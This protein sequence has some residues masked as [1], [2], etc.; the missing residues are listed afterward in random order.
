ERVFLVG[1]RD[2]RRFRFPEPT[3]GTLDQISADLFGPTREPY[4]NAWDVLGDL[5]E[6][7]LSEPGL[8]VG[9]KWGDLLPTIPE[10]EN[11]LWHTNRGGG[12]SLFGWR[13]RYWS[14][15]LKLSKSLPSWTVQ[16]QPGS[17]IGPFHWKNRRLTFQE[18]CRIQT[19]PDGLKIDCGRSEMQ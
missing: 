9:G 11:Y 13:T 5:P 8:K 12:Q 14:F 4:H 18:L 10:G 15:L 19:F 6:P 2:G 17:A 1:S 3:H 16:A 7:D